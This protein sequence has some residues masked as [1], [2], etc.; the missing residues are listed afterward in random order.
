MKQN[1]QRKT[2]LNKKGF[3][4]WLALGASLFIFAI[5][6]LIGLGFMSFMMSF[7][8]EE[9][10]YIAPTQSQM[11]LADLIKMHETHKLNPIQL[12]KITQTTSS[13]DAETVFQHSLIKY[14][15]F[16]KDY[17]TS[18]TYDQKKGSLGPDVIV[19]E[20]TNSASQA[21]VVMFVE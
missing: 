3:G 19:Q 5:L 7:N 13:T 14:I 18:S 1:K 21:K 11:L 4:P 12:L 6:Y 20:S 8:S 10:D 15:E 2:N 9:R 17:A 16:G